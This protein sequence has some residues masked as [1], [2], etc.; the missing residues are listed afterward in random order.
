MYDLDIDLEAIEKIQDPT[1]KNIAHQ[2]RINGFAVTSSDN[3]SNR[4]SRKYP[5][6]RDRENKHKNPAIIMGNDRGANMSFI[7]INPAL[8]NPD[9]E[10][11]RFIKKMIKSFK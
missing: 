5:E 11:E 1:V 6:F 7:S 10:L 4:I 3:I 8:I 2:L 9:K